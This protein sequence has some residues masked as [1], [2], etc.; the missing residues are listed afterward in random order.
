MI[1]TSLKYAVICGL[2]LSAIFIV[3]MKFGSNPLIDVRHFLFDLG[4]FFLFIFFACKEHRHFRNKGKFHFWEGI[5]IG[6]VVF[7]PAVLFFLT[8]LFVL[9]QLYP[10]LIIDYRVG[11][12]EFI[13]GRKEVFL[14][15]FTEQEFNTQI[16]SIDS[17]T[18]SDLMYGTLW[19]KLFAGFFV[20]PIVS[21]I[22]RKK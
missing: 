9:F 10:D 15:R 21:I 2:F 13:E 22:L 16:K 6:F 19:K 4:I 17:I 12:R 8:V 18:S 11:A 14:E 3:S 7:I 1:K 20:T 5:S